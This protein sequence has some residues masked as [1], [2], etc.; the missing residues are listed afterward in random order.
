MGAGAGKIVVKAVKY[1]LE[2]GDVSIPVEVSTS[3][4]IPASLA[5]VD[6]HIEAT[7][8]NSES[9]I[10][11]NVHTKK[12]FDSSAVD[13]STAVCKTDCECANDKCASQIDTCLAD[14]TCAQGQDCAFACA[15]GDDAC[16]LKCAKDS[17][18][19]KALPVA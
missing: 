4:I 2:A 13:C 8:Q 15:C 1:P 18:S 7:E 19:A 12:A 3:A 6:V 11:L 17:P 16:A 14:A 10:C 5:K 9:V